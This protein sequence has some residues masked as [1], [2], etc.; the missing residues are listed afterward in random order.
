MPTK[1]SRPH[2][3]RPKTMTGAEFEH[4]LGNAA[5]VALLIV[6][7]FAVIAVLQIGQVIIAPIMLAV[8]I[9]MMFGPL[10][11][12]MEHRG[13]KPALSAGVVVLVLLALI[14]VAGMLFIG[15]ISEWVKRGPVLW[16]KLQEQL[17]G[18]KQPLESLGAIQEQLKS[19]MGGDSA[20]GPPA[21]SAA[22]P[23]KCSRAGVASAN[24]CA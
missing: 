6:G 13:I 4:V 14:F 5:Q 17:A 7:V 24:S 11:D 9:G 3:A 18:F 16:Q 22:T 8:V 15:P 1:A 21:P 2:R 20:V 23:C 19:A 12:F 10:A